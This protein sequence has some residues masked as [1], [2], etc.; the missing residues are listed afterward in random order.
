[1]VW[2][3]D[4]SRMNMHYYS[5]LDIPN[6]PLRV[7]GL[8]LVQQTQAKMEIVTCPKCG[9][10]LYC[11]KDAVMLRCTCGHTFPVKSY[12]VCYTNIELVILLL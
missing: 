3:S 11:P 10:Q 1:M 6:H 2:M 7:D 5:L 12:S 8:R 9:I 4:Q